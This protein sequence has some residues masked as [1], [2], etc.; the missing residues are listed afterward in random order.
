MKRGE[1]CRN[2]ERREVQE[3]GADE[4]FQNSNLDAEVLY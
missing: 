3:R 2:E 1:R 4:H